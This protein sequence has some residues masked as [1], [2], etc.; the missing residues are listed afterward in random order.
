MEIITQKC[1]GP[2]RISNAISHQLG[3][4]QRKISTSRGLEN[5][6][7]IYL[8]RY[9]FAGT[10]H[11]GSKTKFV[12]GTDSR[13]N[14]RHLDGCWGTMHGT[15]SQL[16]EALWLSAALRCRNKKSKWGRRV[17]SSNQRARETAPRAL[18]LFQPR[19]NKASRAG[20]EWRDG[21]YGDAGPHEPTSRSR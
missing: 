5:E 12:A 13:L 8:V 11:R 2:D 10:Y 6:P 19:S 9:D 1:R 4:S 21:C 3:G 18:L 14:P 7:G 20:P 17:V 15:S 16:G